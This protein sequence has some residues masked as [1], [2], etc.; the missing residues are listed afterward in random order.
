M[1]HSEIH[2]HTSQTF[3]LDVHRE[4]KTKITDMPSFRETDVIREPNAAEIRLSHLADRYLPRYYLG[5]ANQEN[6]LHYVN[7][8]GMKR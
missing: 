5:M 7:S 1:T 2:H 8:A 4:S 6:L 3:S